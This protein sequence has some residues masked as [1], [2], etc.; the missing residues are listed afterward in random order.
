MLLASSKFANKAD[1]VL[2]G[3]LEQKPIPSRMEKIAEGRRVDEE[4]VL[5]EL[6][7][8]LGGMMLYTSGTTNRPVSRICLWWDNRH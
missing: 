2:S 1:D 3:E 7:E 4:V 8:D 6:K 5:K